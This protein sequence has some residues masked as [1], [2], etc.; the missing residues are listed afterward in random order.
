MVVSGIFLF[1]SKVV[2]STSSSETVLGSI[3]KLSE[4]PVV[5]KA[6]LCPSELTASTSPCAAASED[7]RC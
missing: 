4:L 1:P 7:R 5:G 6:N 3:D 2:E